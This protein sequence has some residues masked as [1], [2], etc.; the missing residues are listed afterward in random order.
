M[1]ARHFVIVNRQ[2]ARFSLSFLLRSEVAS[3]VVGH[4]SKNCWGPP[5]GSS[6]SWYASVRATVGPTWVRWGHRTGEMRYFCSAPPRLHGLIPFQQ[7]WD[8]H[9]R[10]MVHIRSYQ[11]F[12]EMDSTGTLEE[13]PN[14]QVWNVQSVQAPSRNP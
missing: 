2:I 13:D 6:G 12:L 11:N 9:L 14:S 1:H 10:S 8:V 4:W 5:E 7:I 3:P